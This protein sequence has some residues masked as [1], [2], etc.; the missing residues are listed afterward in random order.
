[1]N[2]Y[3]AVHVAHTFAEVCRQLFE[4]QKYNFTLKS[5]LLEVPIILYLNC[6]HRQ[7]KK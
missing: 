1:M 4:F 5:I 6:V 7:L 3:R 2:I